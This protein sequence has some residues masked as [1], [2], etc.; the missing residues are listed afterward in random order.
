M[1]CGFVSV[2]LIGIVVGLFWGSYLLRD[3]EDI[4]GRGT[5]VMMVEVDHCMYRLVPVQE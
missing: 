5:D 1:Y 4:L 3:S 2:L